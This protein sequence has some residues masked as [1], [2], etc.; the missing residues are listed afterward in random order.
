M[1]GNR[2]AVSALSGRLLYG[3]DSGLRRNDGMGAM[4]VWGDM[5]AWGGTL[6]YRFA[7]SIGAIVSAGVNPKICP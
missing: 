2:L 4:T 7:I 1:P 6:R 3:A 5:T